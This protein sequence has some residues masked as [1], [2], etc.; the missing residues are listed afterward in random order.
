MIM[1]CYFIVLIRFNNRTDF[2][3]WYDSEDYQEILKYRLM[4][5]ESMAILVEG[6]NP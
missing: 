5:S 4:A 3:A 1:S 6:D 2:K